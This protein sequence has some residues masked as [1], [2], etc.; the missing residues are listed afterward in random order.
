MIGITGLG[1]YFLCMI[2]NVIMNV[3]LKVILLS[4]IE[5]PCDYLWNPVSCLIFKLPVFYAFAGFNIFHVVL[6]LERA[7]I[8]FVRSDM[9]DLL[10]GQFGVIL[11]VTLTR[12]PIKQTFQLVVPSLF[13]G[14]SV[15]K[16]DL[17]TLRPYC[18]IG[19]RNEVVDYGL[20][21]SGIILI[22][23][24]ITTTVLDVVVY[25]FNKRQLKR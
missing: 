7:R 17:V 25:F 23:S 4:A 2:F 20:I 10:F 21:I 3:Y 12:T 11:M 9:N 1:F 6:S 14:W 19:R 15:S 18:F 13:V 8:I 16:S 5:D 22:V 24:D